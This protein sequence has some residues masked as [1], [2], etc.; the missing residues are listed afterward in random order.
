[1]WL[2][3]VTLIQIYNE[4][5][6]AEQGKAENAQGEGE[7]GTREWNGA[8]FCVLANKQIQENPVVKWI[9]RSG[10]LRGETHPAKPLTCEK[11]LKNSLGL[12]LV[13]YAFNPSTQETE[14]L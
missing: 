4:E 7:K 9:K 13:V 6:Q 5:E 1:V 11:E 3:V 8:K 10:V 2:L 14:T 12:G